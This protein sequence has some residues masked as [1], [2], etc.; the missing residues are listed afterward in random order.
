MP[1]LAVVAA[2]MEMRFGLCRLESI[3]LCDLVS[4]Y[5]MLL[6]ALVLISLYN[7]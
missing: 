7:F 1:C 3:E 6:S 2:Y 4:S 5:C